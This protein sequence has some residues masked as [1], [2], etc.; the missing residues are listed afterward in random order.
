MASFAELRQAIKTILAGALEDVHLYDQVPETA[1]LPAIVVQPADATFPFTAARAED[2]WQFDLVVMTSFGD[3]GLAQDQLDVF[4]SGSGPKSIR[5]IFMLNK[6]LG[7]DDVL[8]A[9]VA[10]M[11]DYGANFTM[12]AVENI[13]CKLR[14]VVATTGPA[15]M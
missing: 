8:A 12:A 13:G 1:N 9:Y 2:E 11:S 7:R 4:L 14:V 6:Q 5:Q 15:W 10:G 3:A